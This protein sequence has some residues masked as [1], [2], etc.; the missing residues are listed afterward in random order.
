MV[1]T[2]GELVRINET[3]AV[4]EY[5]QGKLARVEEVVKS[6][7]QTSYVISIGMALI[8]VQETDLRV[9]PDK[10]VH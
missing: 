8:P 10:I 5:V 3:A 4:S 6:D 9:G 7:K 1:F 2:A